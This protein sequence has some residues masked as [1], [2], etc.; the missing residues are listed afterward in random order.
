[1]ILKFEIWRNIGDIFCERTIMTEKIRVVLII[2]SF[3]CPEKQKV[4][5]RHSVCGCK[6]FRWLTGYFRNKPTNIKVKKIILILKFK[7]YRKHAVWNKE[8][9]V[10]GLFRWLLIY[11]LLKLTKKQKK[12]SLKSSTYFK[13]YVFNSDEE[14]LHVNWRFKFWE[15]EIKIL[16]I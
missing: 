14:G 2:F 8:I 6:K 1:M 16:T 15:V 7:I 5:N 10:A 12:W 13:M 9:F 4:K 3:I 11:F